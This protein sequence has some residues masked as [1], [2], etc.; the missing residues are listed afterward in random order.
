MYAVRI[1]W[2]GGAFRVEID[3]KAPSVPTPVQ[4]RAMVRMLL[5]DRFKLNAQIEKREMPVFALY[6]W[7][8]STAGR[9]DEADHGG[10]R[11]HQGGTRSCES[12]D[13]CRA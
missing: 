11:T 1:L 13:S 5:S 9:A 8:G 12:A 7:I 2:M 4:M 6:G 3:A 10:L